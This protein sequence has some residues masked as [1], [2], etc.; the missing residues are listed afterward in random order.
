MSIR[1]LPPLAQLRAF[2]ALAESGSISGAGDLLNVSHA[3]ISQQVRAFE[4]HV[5]VQ[6][7]VKDGRGV[8]LTEDGARLGR[9]LNDGFGAM[10]REIDALTGADAARPLQITTTPMFAGSWLLPRIGDFR[11][12]HPTIDLMINPSPGLTDPAAGGLDLAIRFGRGIW[13][14]LESELLLP[15]DFLIMGAA[16]L[17][18]D[19]TIGAPQDL[20]KYPWLQELGT[21]EV[22]NWLR[23]NGV[24]EKRMNGLTHLPGNL[25]LEALRQGQGIAGTSRAFVEQ[26]IAHGTLKVLFEDPNPGSG[27]FI[28]TRPGPPR[29]ST[30]AFIHWL[31]RQA[32]ADTERT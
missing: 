25:L 20:L 4:N 22:A 7:V 21:N 15:T 31:R 23:T 2:A 13:A 8:A 3:A 24:T 14:G 16:S 9:T 18:G 10:T 29:A 26:D 30:K 32:A 6:L 17:V 11:Q 27:Y 28:V 5:G 19:C 1:S 12:R